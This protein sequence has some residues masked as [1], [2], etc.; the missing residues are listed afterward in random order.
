MLAV[1][2]ALLLATSPP[3][4]IARPNLAQV[5]GA[6]WDDLRLNAFIGNRN[7]LGALWYDAGDESDGKPHFHIRDVR[8]RMSGAADKCSFTLSATAAP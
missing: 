1:L 6:I 7:W 2:L 3:T 8:C 4:A 5:N